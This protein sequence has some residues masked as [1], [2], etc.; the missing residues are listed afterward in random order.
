VLTRGG[1]SDLRSEVGYGAR[2][3]NRFPKRNKRVFCRGETPVNL[4]ILNRLLKQI[5]SGW[6][7]PPAIALASHGL[8]TALFS[9]FRD[10]QYVPSVQT[11]FVRRPRCGTLWKGLC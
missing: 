6:R 1:I 2:V 5:S 11:P 10:F 4:L 3:A 7:E 8:Q 9:R